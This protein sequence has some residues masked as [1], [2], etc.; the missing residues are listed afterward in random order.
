MMNKQDLR[1]QAAI[2]ALSGI[3]NAYLTDLAEPTA[4]LIGERGN[5]DGAD[6]NRM[7]EFAYDV[8]ESLVHERSKR[9]PSE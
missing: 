6:C 1:D 3:V 4:D 2:H 9:I 8:A 5:L 7:A